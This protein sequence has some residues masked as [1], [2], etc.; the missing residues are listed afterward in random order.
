MR[1]KR[2]TYYDI[3][4]EARLPHVIG[5]ADEMARLQRVLGRRM[6]NNALIVGPGG[7]G[8]S[9]LVYGWMRALREDKR[10]HSLA[11]LQL[12]VEHLHALGD[13]GAEERFSEAFALLPS[14]VLFVDDFG[15]ETYQNAALMQQICRLYKQALRRPDVHVVLALEP[16]EYEWLLREHSSFVRLFETVLLKNQNANEHARILRATLP[17][18]NSRHRII[19]SDDSIEEVISYAERY[20]TL[21]QLPRS[22][23]HLL[24]ECLSMS[25][26]KGRRSLTSD[27]IADVVEAKTGVPRARL[28]KDELHGVKVLEESLNERVIDQKSAIAKIAASLQRAKLGLRN[29]KRPLGSFL[30][31]GPSGVG[32]TETAKCVAE[33]MFGRSESFTRFDMSEF[34]Q[35]HT[36]QRLIGAPAGYIG[37]EEGGALTN[38]L[39]KEPHSLILLDE[40]EKAHPKIFD[41]FLQVLDDGRISSG[42]NETVDATNAIFMATSNVGVAEILEAYGK[43]GGID[44]DSL[45]AKS[46][47]PV[48]AQTFR[49]EFINR[50]DSILVFKPLAVPSLVKIAHLEIRKMEKRLAKH[51]VRFEVEPDTLEEELRRFADPRFGARPAKRFIEETCETLL[52]RSLLTPSV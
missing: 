25:T 10:Y 28:G 1:P 24:D 34:Q 19:V 15:R 43:N 20:P 36:V 22:A 32:K 30:L 38:A 11:L 6:S 27:S 31:L 45:V 37:Y 3:S 50:F 17:H 16:H 44:D 2:I 8:K 18:L 48:L 42:Q 7:I 9:T 33:I 52:M 12:D 14:C 51:H 23:I 21:G 4:D 26:S 49:L 35:D 40:I 46:V 41:I 29:P 39:R 5:R 47:M 13:T